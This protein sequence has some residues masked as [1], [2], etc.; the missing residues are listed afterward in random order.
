MVIAMTPPAHK[1]FD[2]E[3]Y[4]LYSWCPTEQG[5]QGVIDRLP[6]AWGKRK[7]Q[8]GYFWAVYVRR[9]NKGG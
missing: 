5:A 7:V 9:P 4:D 3:R 2:G 6:P 1:N 8:D